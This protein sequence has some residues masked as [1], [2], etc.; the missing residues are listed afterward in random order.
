MKR[1]TEVTRTSGI[2][3]EFN[4]IPGRIG[5]DSVWQFFLE[6]KHSEKYQ[7]EW[8]KTVFTASEPD[9]HWTFPQAVTD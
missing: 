1:W 3:P 5:D 6:R 8:T 4:P 7:A 2:P 9:K